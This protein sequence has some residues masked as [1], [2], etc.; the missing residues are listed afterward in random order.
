MAKPVSAASPKVALFPS[1]RQ[2]LLARLVLPRLTDRPP[3][4]N[5]P[6][7]RIFEPA[8]QSTTATACVRAGFEMVI[9]TTVYAVG[10]R[11][12]TTLTE[13]DVAVGLSLL[14]ST[15]QPVAVGNELLRLTAV[16]DE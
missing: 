15:T 10:R 13:K 11:A 8:G 3:E 4:L 14:T 2:P 12:Q 9:G 7:P 16:L 5:P 6:P 1:T